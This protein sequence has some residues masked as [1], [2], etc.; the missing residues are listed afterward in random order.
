MYD[1]DKLYFEV[2]SK[3]EKEIVLGTS[4]L[5]IKSMANTIIASAE[6]IRREYPEEFEQVFRASLDKMEKKE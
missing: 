4:N 1:L 3:I 2:I 5:D 6:I